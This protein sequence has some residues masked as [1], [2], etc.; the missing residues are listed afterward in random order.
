MKE[1]DDFLLVRLGLTEF[2]QKSSSTTDVIRREPFSSVGQEQP[3]CKIDMDEGDEEECH[4]LRHIDNNVFVFYCE[5]G[6]LYMKTSIFGVI[7]FGI[8][9]TLCSCTLS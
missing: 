9:C 7:L 5:F 4:G 1:T 2:V 8:L 6:M 3:R